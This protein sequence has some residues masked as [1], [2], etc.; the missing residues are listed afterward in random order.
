MAS[1][2]DLKKQIKYACGDIAAECIIARD[3]IDNDVEKWNDLVLRI[4]SLQYDSLKNCSF[5]FDKSRRELGSKAFNTAHKQYCAK[6][7]AKLREDFN[8]EVA[9]I[10][11]EMNALLPADM[12]AA[13]KAS[14]SK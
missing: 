10:V 1:K 13:N 5:A 8:N 11:K 7:F 9:E 3:I 12:K 14:Q 6:A 2:R 4:A